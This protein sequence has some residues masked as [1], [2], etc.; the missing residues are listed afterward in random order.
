MLVQKSESGIIGL[1]QTACK[2]LSKHSCGQ[3]GVHQP[4]LKLNGVHR[5]P[6]VSLR[7]IWLNIVFYDA[8]V[9]HS[10]ISSTVFHTTLNQLLQAVS[11]DLSVREYVKH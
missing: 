4:I 10:F 1:I 3:S 9:L 5:N 6:L 2:A 11:A 7:G 8:P